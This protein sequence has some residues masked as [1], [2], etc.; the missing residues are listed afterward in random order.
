[1]E[2]NSASF[3]SSGRFKA[4]FGRFLYDRAQR[5]DLQSTRCSL[6]ALVSKILGS[7]DIIGHRRFGHLCFST[8][9]C[10]ARERIFSTTNNHD[11][12]LKRYVSQ[13]KIENLPKGYSPS[14][15]LSDEFANIPSLLEFHH[16]L[17]M[18]NHLG[19]TLKKPLHSVCFYAF[20]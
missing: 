7:A 6:A 19:K 15:N 4:S 3:Y 1:M 5:V 11:H 10:K 8:L 14:E 20:I 13:L 12:L 18:E 9:A 17:C 2:K 16:S